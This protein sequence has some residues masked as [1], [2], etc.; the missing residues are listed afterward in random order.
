MNTFKGLDLFNNVP[1]ELWTKV[2]DIVQEASNKTI[3]KKSKKA[4]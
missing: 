4:K 2:H 1:K 3:A